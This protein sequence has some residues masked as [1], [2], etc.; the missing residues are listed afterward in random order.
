MPDT[1]DLDLKK[2]GISKWLYRELR[3]FCLQY[4]EKRRR[5]EFGVTDQKRAKRILAD[6]EAV[7]QAAFA[8]GG[9]QYKAL[10]Y[11]E[12]HDVRWF[13]LTQKKGLTCTERE[14]RQMRHRF[15]AELAK[16]LKKI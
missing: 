10:L 7:E 5:L 4:E 16:N 6:V 11:G 13:F 1:R 9:E 14:Y 3:A 2:Y 8:A 15:Y 12:T